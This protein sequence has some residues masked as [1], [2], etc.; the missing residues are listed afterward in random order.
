MALYVKK[1]SIE[2]FFHYLPIF[3]LIIAKYS[4]KSSVYCGNFSFGSAH[5][6]LKSA[7]GA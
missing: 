7:P 2:A 6:L 5:T 4:L 3:F 1:T